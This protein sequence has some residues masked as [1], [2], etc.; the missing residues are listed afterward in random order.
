MARS[1]EWIKLVAADGTTKGGTTWAVGRRVRATGKRGQGLCTSEY[2]H[3]YAS[4]AVA[5]LMAPGHG[6]GGY[7]RAFVVRG[8]SHATDGTKHGLRLCVVLREIE[9]PTLTI[10]Q[11]VAIAIVCAAQ[12]CTDATWRAWARAWLDKSGRSAAAAWAADAAAWAARAAA[13]AAAWAAEAAA[14]AAA[15]A[16][17]AAADAAADAAAIDL[18]AICA[19]V[20]E[21]PEC[22]WG[23]LL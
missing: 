19:R 8:V 21:T 14:W 13:R 17:E 2:L 10:D 3:V 20:L 6:V 16:A 1:R 7:T 23:S 11:C 9:R 18:P 15:R 4:E 22:E 5:A 12:S